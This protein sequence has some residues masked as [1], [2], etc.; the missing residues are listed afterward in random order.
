[1]EILQLNEK[2]GLPVKSNW[3]NE[4]YVPNE[5][6]KEK[7]PYCLNYPLIKVEDKKLQEFESNPFASSFTQ[8]VS[9]YAE[10]CNNNDIFSDKYF[11]MDDINENVGSTNDIKPYSLLIDIFKEMT[12]HLEGYC[13]MNDINEIRAYLNNKIVKVKKE[14]QIN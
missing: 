7:Y 6:K 13:T 9:K 1:M 12:N 2:D 3:F 4:K 14:Q 8:E 10:N 5:S 11:A